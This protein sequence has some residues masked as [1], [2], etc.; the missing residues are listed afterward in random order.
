MRTGIL[1]GELRASFK[2]V[3][4]RVIRRHLFLLFF[5]SAFSALRRFLASALPSFLPLFIIGKL[6]ILLIGSI[7]SISLI[8]SEEEMSIRLK[9]FEDSEITRLYDE[10]HSDP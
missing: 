4:L 8:I 3:L 10:L 5:S 9:Y 7:I 6:T 2:F 1:C